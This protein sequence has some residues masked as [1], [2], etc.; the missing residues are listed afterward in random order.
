[1]LILIPEGPFLARDPPHG[2]SVASCCLA[3]TPV[4]NAQYARF[5]RETGHRAPD[6]SDW[7]RAVWYG[8]AFPSE[9][10]DHPVVCV[11]WDDAAAYCEWAG[12][13]L[14]SEL[15]WEK[16]ARGRDGRRYPWGNSWENG[17]HCR[18]AVK[19]DEGMTCS[20]W[21]H[22]EG[23][24]PWGLWQMCGNVWE[25]CA[26]RAV[27]G[28]SWTY[29]NEAYFR[30]AYRRLDGA[31]ACTP[32]CG[33]RCARSVADAAAESSRPQPAPPAAWMPAGAGDLPQTATDRAGVE[34]LC[35][36]LLLSADEE[37][38]VVAAGVLAHVPTRRA[39]SV[40]VRALVSATPLVRAIA[41]PAL[42]N[43][44][45]PASVVRR[46][47]TA[48]E[49]TPDERMRATEAVAES[50]PTRRAAVEREC[51]RFLRDPAETRELKDAAQLIVAR[52]R[53]HALLLRPVCA[54]PESD[55]DRLLRPASGAPTDDVP[56][57]VRPIAD[58]KPH[59]AKAP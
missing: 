2:V 56:R 30:C 46:L 45:A 49:L 19:R 15:E 40:L 43:R 14:P 42:W 39:I 59:D 8:G 27:R 55:A 12:L 51:L 50:E 41:A 37:E 52:V 24:S 10:A 36:Q 6:H 34:D 4:T 9:E 16:G 22:P 48:R 53:N 32:I 57:L 21:R 54:A 28:G 5:V 47:L 58:P 26:E 31:E 44:A 13:R 3:A 20:V 29:R 17:Q 23:I 25:W 35:E 18:S 33:F 11:S 38:R 1:M 7:G